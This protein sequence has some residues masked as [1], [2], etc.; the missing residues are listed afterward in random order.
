M[1]KIIKLAIITIIALGASC[2]YIQAKPVK[3]DIKGQVFEKRNNQPLAFATI[4]IITDDN[5]IVTG[6]TSGDNGEFKLSA[7]VNGNYKIVISFIGYKNLE[8]PLEITTANSIN[9]GK[10]KLEQDDQ[11][12][13]AT[14]VTAKVPLIEQKLDKVVMNVSESVMAKTNN[15]FEILKRAPGI[16][17]DPDG[18]IL[19]NGQAVEIWIDNRP[20]RVSGTQLETLISAI[21]GNSL[22]K[23]E[24]MQHPSAK[25][26]AAG[27]GGIINIKTKKNFIKGFYGNASLNYT[28]FPYKGSF[29]QG[30]NGS[31]NLNYRDNKTNTYLTYSPRYY[32]NRFGINSTTIFGKEYEN[33]Q[34][35]ESSM[36]GN[37]ITHYAKLGHDVYINDKNTI[38]FLFG[39]TISS[40][41]FNTLNSSAQTYTHNILAE[42]STS[43]INQSND[44]NSLDANLYYT[45]TFN[46]AS[47]FTINA[48]YNYFDLDNNSLQLNKYY[49]PINLKSANSFSNDAKRYINIYSIKADY[50]NIFLKK[51]TIETGI[52][53]TETHTKNNMVRMD[54]LKN[55]FVIND[56]LSSKFNYQEDI[57]AAYVS[58]SYQFSPKW[59]TMAGLRGEY[60]HSKGDWESSDT[61]TTQSYFNVFPTMFIGYTPTENWRLSVS[62]A[63]RIQRPKFMQLNPY[64][65]YVDANSFMEGNPNLKPQYTNEISLSAGYKSFLNFGFI[66]QRTGKFI[67]QDPT[68]DQHTGE[69][70]ILWSNFGSLTMYGLTASLSE[71]PIINKVLFLNTNITLAQASSKNTM[72]NYSNNM[73]FCEI[74]GGF[75]AVLP[76]DFKL[77]LSGFYMNGMPYGYID[78]QSI[79]QIN[80][81][82]KKSFLNNKATLS[83]AVD[84]IFRTVNN[85]FDVIENGKLIYACSEKQ[86]QQKIK[87]GFTYKF[88]NVQAKKRTNKRDDTSNRVGG[89]TGM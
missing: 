85:N 28:A 69:K 43:K 6:A 56:K 12:L 73:F 88:G 89:G 78:I 55:N 30:G 13:A 25:F 48:D 23:I 41:E 59:S 47:D 32:Q 11:Q 22:D 49:N 71:M 58:L 19:L 61:V 68:F 15:G 7:L 70:Q 74:N 44:M 46:Q 77:D 16:S 1:L 38:G 66:F 64:R 36:G 2:A 62:Y 52:K 8:M 57:S 72:E 9:L 20:S 26:D 53:W 27:S 51:G 40:S 18:N 34:N 33:E 79:C 14:I 29:H 86:Y 75:T 31:I 67:S 87:I 37:N 39:T 4:T 65:T 60:T 3:T 45:K 35:S 80:F 5:K 81:A 76:K 84:D 21:D 83:F 10:L 63:L 50:K 54:S 24:I 17:I 42:K 82:V